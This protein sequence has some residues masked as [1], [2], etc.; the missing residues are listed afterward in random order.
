MKPMSRK[1]NIT[2][3]IST[4]T[5]IQALS[6][7]EA[8]LYTWMIPHA[9]D[10]CTIARKHDNWP[11]AIRLKV[12]PGRMPNHPDEEIQQAV[13]HIIQLGLLIENDETISFPPKPFYKYQHYVPLDRRM[14]GANQ[15]ESA[16]NGEDPR[17]S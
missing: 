14:S 7:F 3:N 9:E 4:D 8:L 16:Q 13:N 15:R 17:S 1:R 10:D 5:R 12:I 2:E 11:L 6:D